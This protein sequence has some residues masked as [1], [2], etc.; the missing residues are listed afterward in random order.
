MGVDFV[1]WLGFGLATGQK[2]GKKH[3]AKIHCDYWGI[4]SGECIMNI[5][6]EYRPYRI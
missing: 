6:N 2:C 4:E 3:L 1:L 5:Y